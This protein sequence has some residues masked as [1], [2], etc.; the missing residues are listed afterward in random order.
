MSLR[1]T[2]VETALSNSASH[3]EDTN[4]SILQFCE[5]TSKKAN[6]TSSNLEV[7]RR[8]VHAL[9]QQAEDNVTSLNTCRAQEESHNDCLSHLERRLAE[10]VVEQQGPV[11]AGREPASSTDTR[12]N[13]P[14][15]TQGESGRKA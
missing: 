4:K 1:L 6:E 11:P 3:F 2:Q 10:V 7:V 15:G 8:D 5:E 12:P 13:L 9:Q 14:P